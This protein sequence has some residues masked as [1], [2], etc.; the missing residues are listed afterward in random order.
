M[1]EEENI[2]PDKMK[3]VIIAAIGQNRE[4]GRDNQLLWHLAEDMQ[5]FKETTS[6]HFVIMG[7]K[8]FDSI[9]KKYK[10]LP[11]RVN[12]IITR[13]PDYMYEECYTF[14]NLQ[15]A[16]DLANENGEDRVFIIG[17]GEIYRLALESGIVDEM[18]LTEVRASFSDAHIFF[19]EFEHLHWQKELIRSVV[20]DSLNQFSFDIYHY[21]KLE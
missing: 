12:I 21:Q 13:D 18:F 3:V 19:P 9:P 4:L 8:S 15:E 1:E 11:N 2:I 16:I 6:R 20:A 5:F 10:P 17:G 7:R 14:S